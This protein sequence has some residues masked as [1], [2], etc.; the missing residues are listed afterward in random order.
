M[1]FEIVEK[2]LKDGS[3]KGKVI[4]L[5]TCLDIPATREF[6]NIAV[7]DKNSALFIRTNLS[8]KSS[9]ITLEGVNVNVSGRQGELYFFLNSKL[10][11]S[12]KIPLT[13]YEF[14]NEVDVIIKKTL[15]SQN[16]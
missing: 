7:N 9:E 12:Q 2:M 13:K 11:T 8:S 16:G 1:K 10:V 14:R 3:N 15:A 6:E 4:V 5:Q